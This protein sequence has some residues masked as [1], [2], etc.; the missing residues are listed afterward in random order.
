MQF[1][2]HPRLSSF[3]HYCSSPLA[4]CINGS[5]NYVAITRTLSGLL[6]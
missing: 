5:G 3:S 4:T 1:R 2:L 6:V